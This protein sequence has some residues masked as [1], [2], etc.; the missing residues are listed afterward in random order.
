MTNSSHW[1]QRAILVGVFVAFAFGLVIAPYGYTP[2]LSIVI[3]LLAG[4][5][6]LLKLFILPQR[7]SWLPPLV[8]S[9]LSALMIVQ[10]M[11]VGHLKGGFRI[12]LIAL[13]AFFVVFGA[14]GAA[15]PLLEKKEREA[16]G[17]G[18]PLSG[19]RG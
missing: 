6:V 13:L 2:T 1:R 4:L 11:H 8:L 17:P 3:L 7:A 14:L 16:G 9:V 12:G 19:N 15:V 18:P 5:M 10:A